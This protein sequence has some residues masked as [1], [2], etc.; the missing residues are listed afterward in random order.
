M[1]WK[2]KHG[3]SLSGCWF[4]TDRYSMWLAEDFKT[5]ALNESSGFVVTKTGLTSG[6]QWDFA[7]PK[8]FVGSNFDTGLMDECHSLADQY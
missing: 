6:T 4:P 5:D 2:Q 8:D 1:V 3:F 7:Q